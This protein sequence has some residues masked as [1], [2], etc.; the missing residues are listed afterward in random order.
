M[1]ALAQ[2]LSERG[3]DQPEVIARRIE[4]AS[5]QLRECGAFDYLVV[6]DD[7]ACAHD[8]FQAIIVAELMRVKRHPALTESF[9]T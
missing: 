2:R 7:L 5:L 4:E 6:N 8:Q 3:T 1:N 9:S